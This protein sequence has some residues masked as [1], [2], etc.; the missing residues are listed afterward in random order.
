MSVKKLNFYIDTA[1]ITVNSEP[2]PIREIP[3]KEHPKF[4]N[5]H[6]GS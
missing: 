2:P 4:Q 1:K 5:E 6:L 3:G